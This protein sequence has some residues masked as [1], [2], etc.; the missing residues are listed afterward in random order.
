MASCVLL[1]LGAGSQIGLFMAKD[2]AAGYKGA[3]AAS[4]IRMVGGEKVDVKGQ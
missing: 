4:S 1:V 2:F 3:L